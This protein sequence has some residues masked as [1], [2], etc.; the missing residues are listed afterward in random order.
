VS[1]GQAALRAGELDP[2][3]DLIGGRVLPKLCR[4]RVALGG[5]SG[6]ANAVCELAER[7]VERAEPRAL[8]ARPDADCQRPD[9]GYRLPI[10][11]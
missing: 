10:G 1:A 7:V 11:T 5:V 8:D 6:L 3:H 4:R 2:R 9:L